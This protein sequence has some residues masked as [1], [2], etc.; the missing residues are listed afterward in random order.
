MQCLTKLSARA[1]DEDKMNLAFDV[2]DVNGKNSLSQ[3]EV[4]DMLSSA[5]VDASALDVGLTLSREQIDLI[6]QNT[7]ASATR[8]EDGRI[9][10]KAYLELAQQH[11]LSEFLTLNAPG[12]TGRLKKTKSILP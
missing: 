11:R 5:V 2:L 3:D 7:F 1:P 10:R 9:D 12:V 6:V 8:T 4:A